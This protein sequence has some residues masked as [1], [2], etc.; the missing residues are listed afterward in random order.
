MFRCKFIILFYDSGAQRNFKIAYN[1]KHP[2][3]QDFFTFAQVSSRTTEQIYK[4]TH[5]TQAE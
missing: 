2:H 1:N 3:N 4:R 5:F